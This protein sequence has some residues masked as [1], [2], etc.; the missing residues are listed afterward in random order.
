MKSRVLSLILLASSAAACA[1]SAPA[2]GPA[3]RGPAVDADAPPPVLALLSERERLSLT[4]AQVAAVDS[5]ARAWDVQNHKLARRMGA[6]RTKSGLRLGLALTRPRAALAAVAEN[7]RRAAQAVEQVL[8]PDQRRQLCRLQRAREGK[9]ALR[10]DK[11]GAEM[12]AG[13][14]VPGRSLAASRGRRGDARRSWPWCASP[15]SSYASSQSGG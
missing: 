3:P 14:G 8:D 4:P 7:N 12:H 15:G 13:T 6:F 5:I 2:A 1:P 10:A 9:V 11:R